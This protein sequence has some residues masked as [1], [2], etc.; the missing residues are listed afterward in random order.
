[1]NITDALNTI[2][3]K[4]KT[5]KMFSTPNGCV[6]MPPSKDNKYMVYLDGGYANAKDLR[7]LGIAY[8]TIADHL[9]ELNKDLK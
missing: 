8:Q 9:D 5:S 7:E 6:D 3:A 4:F 1:M 2:G